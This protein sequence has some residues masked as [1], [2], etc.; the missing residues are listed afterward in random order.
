MVHSVDFLLRGFELFAS[1]AELHVIVRHRRIVQALLAS[2]Y[3]CLGDV[4]LFFN[5]A[6]L[7]LLLMRELFRFGR[8][9]RVVGA[10]FLGTRRSIGRL[11][12]E[13]GRKSA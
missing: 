13:K 8:A 5:A 12:A 2:R 3:Q 6:Q 1:R 7:A 11:V 9:A 4:N 10:C